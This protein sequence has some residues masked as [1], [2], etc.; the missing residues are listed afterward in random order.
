M[1]DVNMMMTI[2][3][4]AER[5]EGV[6]TAS[7]IK[8]ALTDGRIR[9]SQPYGPGTS[10]Y[11]DPTD[12]KVREWLSRARRLHEASPTPEDLRRKVEELGDLL[13]E[14]R[15]YSLR[16]LRQLADAERRH[17]DENLELARRY[18]EL[19]KRYESLASRV[20]AADARRAARARRSMYGGFRIA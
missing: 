7:G 6:V 14:E 17:A 12:P 5:V 8:R 1:V 4:L 11:V 2:S 3:E 19:A 9:G 10:W 20:G 13:S 16:L 15:L 18:R